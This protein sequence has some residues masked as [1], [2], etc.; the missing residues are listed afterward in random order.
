MD[1][2]KLIEEIISEKALATNKDKMGLLVN[3]AIEGLEFLLAQPLDGRSAAVVAALLEEHGSYRD[4][5]EQTIA[6]NKAEN[7]TLQVHLDAVAKDYGIIIQDKTTEIDKLQTELKEAQEI[8]QDAL[9]GYNS[10][11]VQVPNSLVTEVEGQRVQVN[12]GVQFNGKDYTAADLVESPD[13][14][15]EL[16]AIGSGS[17][18]ILED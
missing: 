3:K 4:E 16:I 9:Q 7:E 18:T 1:I 13:V 17:I 8:A 2:K 12:F 10:A 6:A 15:A 11:A 14:V 5:A